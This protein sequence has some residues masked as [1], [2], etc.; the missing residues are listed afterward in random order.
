MFKRRKRLSR[1]AFPAVLRCGR[2]LSSAHFTLAASSEAEGYAVVV[3][4]KVARLSVARHKMKRR[5]LAALRT[6]SLPRAL[7]VMPKS[8]VAGLSYASVRDELAALLLKSPP[9]K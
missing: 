8:S 4:K 9:T 7:I 6:L 3:S 1:E 5:V 2:R